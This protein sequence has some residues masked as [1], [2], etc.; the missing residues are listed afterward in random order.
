MRP[1]E[2]LAFLRQE[3]PDFCSVSRDIYNDK[4]KGCREYL[5]GRMP[6]QA[7]F[8]ELQAKNYC[9]DLS[10]DAKGQICSLMFANSQSIALAAEFCD[11]TVLDCTYKTNK[12][13][14]PMLIVSASPRLASH[15]SFAQHLC[16]GRTRRTTNRLKLLLRRCLRVEEMTKLREF[17]SATTIWLS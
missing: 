17:G 4:Q 14:M 8:D 3:Y 15:S 16:Q 1:K 6:I 11:V 2:Q 13:K 9:Y 12:F 7:L 10:L 5:N